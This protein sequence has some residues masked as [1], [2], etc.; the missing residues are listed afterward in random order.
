MPR[1][2]YDG[3]G[4]TGRIVNILYL[5]KQ[6]LLKIPVLYLSRYINQ[7]KIEYYQLLQAVREEQAWED[8]VLFILTGVEETSQQTI[9]LVEEIK[10]LMLATKQKMRSELP[11]IYSQDLLNNLFR[12]PYTKIEFVMDELQVTRQTAAKYLD[13]LVSIGLLQKHRIAKGNFYLNAELYGL[14]LNANS[15]IIGKPNKS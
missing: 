6:G 8:W 13:T 11:R 12:H 10:H 1:L 14:L 5:V 4:R 9:V 2:L 15:V 3:N 7:N